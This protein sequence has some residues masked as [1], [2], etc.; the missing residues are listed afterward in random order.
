MQNA[1][2]LG[3]RLLHWLA[4]SLLLTGVVLWL[5]LEQG[6]LTPEQ[7]QPFRVD[8]DA[9]C[10]LRAGPCETRLRNG[11]RVRFG[12]LPLSIPVAK[13]LDVEVDV[14][15]L[16]VKDVTLDLNGVNMKMPPNLVKLKSVT[17]GQFKGQAGLMLCSRNAMEWEARVELKTVQGT[18]FMVPYRFI[19]VSDDNYGE[20]TN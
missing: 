16:D 14:S 3:V 20:L 5:M 13:T 18:L 17:R 10:D 8:F 19:T 12:I 7:V 4:A 15:G 6:W 1:T 9:N 2:L 11:A